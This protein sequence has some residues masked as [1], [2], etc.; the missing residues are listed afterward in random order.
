M[1][2]NS[3]LI[4]SALFL[5]A[6]GLLELYFINNSYF[7]SQL[8]KALIFTVFLFT[9]SLFIRKE[10]ILN[11][12]HLIYYF[13]LIL[14]IIV[15]IAGKGRVNR[16]INLGFMQLQPSEIAKL[17][18]ILAL[19][20]ILSNTQRPLKIRLI[21]AF[22]YTLF[23]FILVML[24]PDLGTALTFL[25]IAFLMSWIS[26]LDPFLTRL[27]I[28]T[29]I[30]M[31]ASAHLL[32][33]TI[34]FLTL[35][36]FLL[37]SKEVLYKK[38]LTISFLTVVSLSTPFVWKKML[39]PYQRYRLTAFLNPE[40]SKSREGWQ[41]YQAKIAV[42]SGGIFGKGP[43]K[44]TQK[45][46]A[47]LPAAHTDF[48]FTSIG[49]EFGFV[50]LIIIIVTFMAFLS[51]LLRKIEL[52]EGQE[53]LILT[54]IFAYFFFHFSVNI[55]SNLSLLPVVGIPLPFITYGGSHLLTEITAIFLVL[56]LED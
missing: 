35:L 9:I 54:G 51:F 23:P 19:S 33:T 15:L 10:H 47:F 55:L 37:I 7:F 2:R 39:K 41:I 24:Q 11:Y 27:L 25:F 22:A 29:P 34:L 40:K 6:I 52:K 5:T 56:K 4:T 16:W 20:K 21:K 44:G 13:S 1:K 46:L 14:L 26:G 48:M 12:G 43:G 32:S 30:T 31:I 53:K 8:S 49:E 17:G 28:L 42:G 3:V 36:I 50:G 38:I 18:L 45:G